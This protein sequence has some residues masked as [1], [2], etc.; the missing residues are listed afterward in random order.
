VFRLVT[1]LLV[2]Y[3]GFVGVFDQDR[4]GA[5]HD[6]QDTNFLD[7]LGALDMDLSWCVVDQVRADQVRSG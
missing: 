4:T 1:R 6:Q 3:D 5:S 2:Y 7:S